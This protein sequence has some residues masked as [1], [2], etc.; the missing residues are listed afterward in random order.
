M[1]KIEEIYSNYIDHL[2]EEWKKNNPS[3][4]KMYRAS[5]SGMCSRKIFIETCLDVEPTNLPNR[6]T[7]RIF[8]LGQI[9]H[10]DL[11]NA[12]ELDSKRK[13]KEAKE[14]ENIYIRE[15]FIEKY[16]EIPEINVR[17]YIDLVVRMS[18]DKVYVY[19]F[20]SI[21]SYPYKL[22]FGRKANR[23]TDPSIHQEMQLSIY[24]H[25]IREEF[26]R[27]DGL[28]LVYYN[29][30]TSMIRTT[31]VSMDYIDHSVDFWYGVN[32]IHKQAKAL[33]TLPPFL[34][35]VSPVKKWECSYCNYKDYCEERP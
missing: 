15:N 30:D 31:E 9:I 25:A 32:R 17:G 29:K 2:S 26:G 3:D 19:D 33:D 5:S 28:F 20:K 24:G 16:I 7:F 21:A 8:R 22:K 34:D 10:E 11:Q 12:I 13:R 1:I 14:K 4:K 6:K 18:D 35:G 23:E 27:L